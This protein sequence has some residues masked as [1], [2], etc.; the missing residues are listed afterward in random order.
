MTLR[1]SIM[2]KTN[3]QLIVMLSIIVLLTTVVTIIFF[4]QKLPHEL[5]LFVDAQFKEELTVIDYFTYAVTFLTSAAN[6][7][8]LFFV[9]WS[10]TVFSAGV[11]IIAILNLFLGPY[12]ATALQS[13]LD[14]FGILLDGF[15]IALAY[16]SN[17]NTYFE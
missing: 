7:G 13:F 4:N 14:S 15:I 12:V 5:N 3:F 11:I 17:V 2:T 8:L 9:R 16:F 6:I 10:R 1:G